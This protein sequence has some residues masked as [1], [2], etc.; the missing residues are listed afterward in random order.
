[1]KAEAA[2]YLSGSAVQT[3][4]DHSMGSL[5]FGARYQTNANGGASSP[6]VNL[7][8]VEFLLNSAAMGD[9][10]ADAFASGSMH[11]T[12][13]LG[14]QGDTFDVD[15]N[16][17]GSLYDKHSEL[18]TAAGEIHFGPVFNLKR[19]SIP[20][21]TLGV[22]AIANGVGLKGDPYLYTLG[23]GTV[24]TTGIDPRTVAH[25]RFAT[26]RHCPSTSASRKPRGSP[27]HF[28][29]AYPSARQRVG[30]RPVGSRHLAE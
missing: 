22:Y 9:P 3:A 29:T 23:L 1:M 7:N 8:G 6:W 2:A 26:D 12:H 5:M 10:D 11:F 20:Q 16:L 15:V 21:S 24:L 25:A 30:G 14:T 18:D 19:F 4:A 28:R 17:Y 27:E 13:D